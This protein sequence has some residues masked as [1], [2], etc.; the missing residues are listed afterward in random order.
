MGPRH[1]RSPIPG[2]LPRLSPP[3]GASLEVLTFSPVPGRENP[4]PQ[5]P[6]LLGEN[7]AGRHGGLRIMIFLVLLLVLLPL[8]AAAAGPAEAVVSVVGLDDQGEPCRQG[9]GTVVGKDGGILTS[10][11]L[12]APGRGGIIKTASGGKHLIRAVRGWDFLEDLALAQVEVE[13][14]PAAPLGS[15]KG[16]GLEEP[17]WVAVRHEPPVLKEA[18]VAKVLS[19]SPRLVL[20]KL[21]PGDLETDL[22]API[23]N[24]RGELVGM[25]HSFVGDREKSQG[26]R[27]FLALDRSHLPGDKHLREEDLPEWPENPATDPAYRACRAFWEGVAAT[28]RQ[29][30]AGAREKFGAALKP[31]G[32]MPEAHY[33]RGVAYFNLGE[34]E[35]AVQDFLQ[36]TGAMPGYALAFLWLGKGWERQGKLEAALGAYQKAVAADPGLSE[37]W[38]RWGTARYRQG[39]LGQAQEYLEKAGDDFPQAAQR[40]W[41]LGIIYQSRQRAA[42]AAA[43]FQ[44]AIRLD[45]EF[46]PAYLEGGKVLVKDLGKAKEA[47]TLLKEAVR[48]RPRHPVARYYLGLAYVTAWNPGGAWEQYFALQEMNS[49]LA[50]RLAAV[51]E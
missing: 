25:L 50:L 30:W 28:L 45:P 33:G 46:F 31:P 5:W 4:F 38:F 23:F 47:V 29:D 10:A 41:Y 49:D 42:E 36:A 44:R 22:G 48:L 8:T 1:E 9:L 35:A 39:D 12:L 18:R 21:E 16:V 11:A 32:T 51:L 43:A 2:G 3:L 24:T 40:W 19:F 34:Y 17:V 20:L 26:F 7:R 6:A 15:S 14:L 27:F 37:A 13:V